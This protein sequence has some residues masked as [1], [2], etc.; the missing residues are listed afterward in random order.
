MLVFVSEICHVSY[1]W[2]TRSRRVWRWIDSARRF[3]STIAK[4]RECAVMLL[5]LCVFSRRC[6]DGMMGSGRASCQKAPR[7]SRVGSRTVSQSVAWKQALGK[8]VSVRC[9]RSVCCPSFCAEKI[10]ATP[11]LPSKMRLSAEELP[12]RTTREASS[13]SSAQPRTF[14]QVCVHVWRRRLSSTLPVLSRRDL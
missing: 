14:A 6:I 10:S 4:Q 11:I 3:F 8:G 2:H 5:R 1:A 9:G 7:E 13:S 12:P